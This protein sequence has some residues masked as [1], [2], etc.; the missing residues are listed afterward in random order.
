MEDLIPGQNWKQS[1][2]E[3]IK[4]SEYFIPLFSTNSVTRRGYVQRELKEALDVLNEIPESKI[5]VIPVRL[6]GST[7]PDERLR[8]LHTADLYPNWKKGIK[9]IMSSINDKEK[10]QGI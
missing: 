5:F 3:A 8:E 6:D 7:I 9:L 2:K 1:I 10:M 4:N